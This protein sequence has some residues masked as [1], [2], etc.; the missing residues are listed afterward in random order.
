MITQVPDG[1][2]LVLDEAYIE[3]APIGS[4]PVVDETDHRVVRMRTFS[5]GYGMAGARVGYAIGAVDLITAFNKVRNHFGMCRI[6][7]AG[8]LAALKDQEW[9]AK[10]QNN[11]ASARARISQIAA[12]NGLTALPSATNFVTIDCGQN[13]AF[14]KRVLGHLIEAGI[15]VRMPFVAPQD[16][17]I[18]VSCGT[19][20]DLDAF[21][22]ALP[23]ALE[24][25]RSD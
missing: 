22:A 20:I 24:R 10:V 15:F 8:A 14:A 19:S 13:G 23:N 9:L 2:L 16:R 18:R 5:K 6:S 4:A 11:V 21:A 12:D 17:C 1:C 25:A 3:T 7:Q